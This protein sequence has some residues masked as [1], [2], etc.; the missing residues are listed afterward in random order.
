MIELRKSPARP[1]GKEDEM[2]SENGKKLTGP[3]AYEARKALRKTKVRARNA[4]TPEERLEKSEAICARLAA[5]K[6]YKNAKN[7]MIYKATK[8]EVRLEP[9]EKLSKE[10]KDGKT[11]L[12]P[13]CLENSAMTALLPHGEEAWREGYKGIF[14]PDPALSDEFAPE[15]I[16][17]VV[18]P[19]S[20]FDE[21]CGRMGMGKGFYDRY[22]A[23]CK[24]A[25]VVAVAFECQKSDSV[26]S[27]PWDKPM[28]AVFTE[29]REYR[30][31]GDRKEKPSE[32]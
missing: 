27:Q 3:E 6:E 19:C 1:D 4:L 21:E 31:P 28:S 10:Q 17:L 7:V 29:E 18:C 24:K 23:R 2:S 32:R 15:D 30:R 25:A 13:L 11:L 20:S 9:L 26:I 12:Y 16:D 22:I 8:G 14:E 5:S